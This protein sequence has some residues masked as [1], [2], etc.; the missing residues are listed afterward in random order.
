ML[1]GAI[2]G[3]IAGSAYE[4]KPAK[5]NDFPLVTHRSTFTDDTV[6]TLA[7]AEWLM[8]E[9]KSTSDLECIMQKFGALYPKAGYGGLFRNW[10]ASH[11]PKPYNSFGNGSAMRV[12]ACAWVS[13]DLDE[14]IELAKKSAEVT[15]NHP[16]GIKGAQATAA[17]I[18]MARK[19]RNVYNHEDAKR[20]IKTFITDKF[21][22]DLNRTVDDII[23]SGYKFNAT[24]QGSVPEAIIAFLESTDFE[25]AIRNVIRLKGDA[26]TQACIAGAIAEALYGIPEDFKEVVEVVLDSNL[27]TIVKQFNEKFKEYEKFQLYY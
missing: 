5:D 15:H 20:V 17:A 13:H 25:S 11:S 14:V 10:L 4:F 23:K 6:M 8:S 2:F 9:Y 27:L 16:E 26:D 24:C 1:Y 12:S 22:Y 18:F 19:L 3:D 7:V 21:G